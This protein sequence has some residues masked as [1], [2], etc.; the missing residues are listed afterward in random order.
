MRG[1][2]RKGQDGKNLPDIQANEDFA[3]PGALVAC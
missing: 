2:A 3:H 1:P